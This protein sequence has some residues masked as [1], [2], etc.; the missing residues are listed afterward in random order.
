MDLDLEQCVRMFVTP[1]PVVL[2]IVLFQ[3]GEILIPAVVLLA[4]H[5]VGPVFLAIPLVVVVVLLVV[6]GTGIAV[7]G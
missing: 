3:S 6:V 2:A 1:A 4:P 7:V 5:P